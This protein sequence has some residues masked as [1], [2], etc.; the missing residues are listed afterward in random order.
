MPL[1][2]SGSKAARQTN[3]KEMIAAGHPPKQAVAA[4]YSNQRRYTYHKIGHRNHKSKME[5]S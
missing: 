5:N 1:I 3:I 2:K 4:A